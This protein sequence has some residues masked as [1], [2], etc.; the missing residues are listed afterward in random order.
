M[1]GFVILLLG[2]I[3]VTLIAGSVQY[4]AA[5][6]LLPGKGIFKDEKHVNLTLSIDTKYQI[7]LQITVKNAQGQLVGI[8]DYVYHNQ[9][10]N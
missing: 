7:Y 6:H 4:A 3:F 5:D 10:N 8:F 1:K 9:I 2:I